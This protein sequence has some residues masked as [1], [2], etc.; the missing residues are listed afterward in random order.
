[1][2]YLIVLLFISLYSNV[3]A[4]NIFSEEEDFV[5]EELISDPF[6]KFN[7]KVYK[8]NIAIDKYSLK[9]IAKTYRK[10]VPTPVKKSLFNFIENIK[11][12]LNVINSVLQGKIKNSARS[13]RDFLINSTIGI[14][15]LFNASQKIFDLQRSNKE[16]LGQVLAAYKIPQGPYLMVPFLGPYSLRSGVGSIG[17]QFYNPFLYLDIEEYLYA[18]YYGVDL[19]IVREGLLD[20]LDDIEKNSLDPYTVIKSAYTQNRN[21]KINE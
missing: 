5:E 21:K 16:D 7:R 2:K 17:E 14:A 12:P 19:V 10:V 20:S 15:G 8:F 3:Y 18:V 4:I 9:P 13:T 6:E 1:M 11:L